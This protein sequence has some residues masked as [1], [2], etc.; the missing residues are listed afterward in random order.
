MC[1]TMPGQVVRVEDALAEI[2]VDGRM[3]R[4]S[5]RLLPATR[6]GDWV[7]LAAGTVIDR[8]SASE[9]IEMRAALTSAF[10]A[11]AP[12]RDGQGRTEP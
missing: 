10:Q 8:L 3:V 2:D 1:V 6:P 9:A 5:T 4:A 7:M 12:D 11:A